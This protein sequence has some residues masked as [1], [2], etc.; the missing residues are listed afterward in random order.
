MFAKWDNGLMLVSTTEKSDY[1]PMTFTEAP[2]AP[3][4]YHA[5]FYWRE[6]ED[7]F[8]QTWELLPEPE[9]EQEDAEIADYEQALADL[10]VRL[11]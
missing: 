4:G 8:V 6:T 7:A 9:P 1:K 3:S 10:G 5:V 11:E 2:T